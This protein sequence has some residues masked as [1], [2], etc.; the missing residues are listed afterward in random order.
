MPADHNQLPLAHRKFA[1]A[2]ARTR[3]IVQAAMA[4][5]YSRHI[6]LSQGSMLVANDRVGTEI[7][8]HMR[9]AGLTAEADQFEEDW[10][11]V[12]DDDEPETLFDRIAAARERLAL[13]SRNGLPEPAEIEFIRTPLSRRQRRAQQQET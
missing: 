4:A 8:A 11:L 10:G 9:E 5:G 1:E 6:A 3:S 7:A 13:E 2:Y 12:E